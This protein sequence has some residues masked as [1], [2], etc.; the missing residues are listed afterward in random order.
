MLNPTHNYHSKLI[1]K[2][3]MQFSA[4]TYN[5]SDDP[6][7]FPNQYIGEI[8]CMLVLKNE[9]LLNCYQNFSK[10]IHVNLAN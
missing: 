5:F 9:N 1:I 10:R 8:N 7:Y 3:K 4:E 6:T 2:D